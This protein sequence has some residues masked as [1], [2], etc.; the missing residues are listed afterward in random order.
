MYCIITEVYIDI[1]LFKQEQ[2]NQ[3]NHLSLEGYLWHDRFYTVGLRKK[4]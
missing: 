4:Y 3:H 1:H 2:K